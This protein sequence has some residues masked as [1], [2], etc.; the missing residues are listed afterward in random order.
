MFADR[1][2]IG[3]LIELESNLQREGQA[4]AGKCTVRDLHISNG[5][6][7]CNPETLPNPRPQGEKNKRRK[8]EFPLCLS[9]RFILSTA[10][11]A[12]QLNH[13]VRASKPPVA[14]LHSQKKNPHTIWQ[15]A[16]LLNFE[17]MHKSLL[18]MHSQCFYIS[19]WEK[20]EMFCKSGDNSLI[21]KMKGPNWQ[22]TII[23]KVADQL[24]SSLAN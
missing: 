15:F 10:V 11:S 2:Q 16:E 20:D 19:Q 18:A 4:P 23:T 9:I 6:N 14:Y 5:R 7:E 8:E 21:W 22:Q 1:Q 24:G 13:C 3:N 12:P 17:P